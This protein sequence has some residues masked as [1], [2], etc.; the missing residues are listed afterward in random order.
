M[1]GINPDPRGFK[2]EVK[3]IGLIVLLFAIT[4]AAAVFGFGGIVAAWV[5]VAL[6]VFWVALALFAVALLYRLIA[7]R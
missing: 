4:V 6:I 5:D 3:M 1:G 7:R 2:K